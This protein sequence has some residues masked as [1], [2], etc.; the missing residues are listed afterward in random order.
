MKRWLCGFIF[1]LASSPALAQT[2]DTESPFLSLLFTWAPV[3]VL[4]LFWLFFMRNMGGGAKG[5]YRE[6]LRTS[7]EKTELIERHLADI[8]QSLRTIAEKERERE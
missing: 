3:L 8:A 6:Y 7:R 4:V 5:G 1:L 2:K